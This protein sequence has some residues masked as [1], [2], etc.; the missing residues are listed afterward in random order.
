VRR[1]LTKTEQNRKILKKLQKMQF[2]SVYKANMGLK[3]CEKSTVIS[4]IKSIKLL[5][6]F[7]YPTKLTGEKLTAKNKEL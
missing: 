7:Y 2:L 3:K 1:T 5:A 4:A 6:C